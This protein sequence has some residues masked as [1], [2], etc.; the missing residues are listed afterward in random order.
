MMTGFIC[1]CLLDVGCF[2]FS[3]WKKGKAVIS[4]GNAPLPLCVSYGVLFV[5]DVKAVCS[6][7]DAA[8]SSFENVQK[9]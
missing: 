1:A 3:C 4:G 2:Q 7:T 5:Q 8:T 6:L 9:A